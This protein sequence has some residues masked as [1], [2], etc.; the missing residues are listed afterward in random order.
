MWARN[1][2]RGLEVRVAGHFG[3]KRLLPAIFDIVCISNAPNPSV[4]C[5]SCEA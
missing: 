2:V 4:I 5:M 1:K 3:I